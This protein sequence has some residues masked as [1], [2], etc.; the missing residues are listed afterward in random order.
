[1]KTSWLTVLA[2]LLYAGSLEAHH[3]LTN[4]DTTKAVRV[5]GTVVEVRTMNPH[6]AI[7]LEEKAAD[8]QIRRWAIEGPAALQL[9]RLGFTKTTLK[10]GGVIEVCGYLPKETIKWQVTATD[11][12]ATSTTRSGRLFN[13]ETLIFPDGKEQSWGDYGVHK[14]FAAGYADQHSTR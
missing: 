1:M 14:C 9:Q 12:S 13:A 3:S 6:S 7:F 4:Y 10:P 5:K 11:A 8:G 2:A